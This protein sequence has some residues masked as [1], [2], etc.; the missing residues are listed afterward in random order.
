MLRA[1]PRASRRRKPTASAVGRSERAEANSPARGAR[2][3]TRVTEAAPAHA[4]TPL[5]PAPSLRLLRPRRDRRHPQPHQSGRSY[6]RDGS[7]PASGRRFPRDRACPPRPPAQPPA[8]HPDGIPGQTGSRPPWRGARLD[9]LL[10]ARPA[11]LPL[12]R[13]RP[14]QGCGR[15][16]REATSSAG[17]AAAES[18][19]TRSGSPSPAH[20]EA[21]RAGV[22]G[23]PGPVRDH[24]GP[25][26]GPLPNR[27]L[28]S[29]PGTSGRAVVAGRSS[30]SS[31]LSGRLTRRSSQGT[32]FSAR[33]APA[34]SDGAPTHAAPT[35]GVQ[36]HATPTQGAPTQG[37]STQGQ[38]ARVAPTQDAPTQ[39]AQATR[40][41]HA[42]RSYTAARPHT[43]RR[44]RRKRR[45]NRGAVFAHDRQTDTAAA[46][47]PAATIASDGQTDP[48][49]GPRAGRWA[50]HQRGGPLA[51]QAGQ[52]PGPRRDWRHLWPRQARPV[53]AGRPRQRRRSLRRQ[54][55]PRTPACAW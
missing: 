4:P 36:A 42:G 19:G 33:T 25:A 2:A 39:G 9:R 24:G 35:Q 6:E 8:A 55:G 38:Q 41:A 13:S 32:R 14:R 30:L 44:G 31:D 20:R 17:T 16:L 34:G 15:P 18:A 26:A 45:A 22:P 43:G 49:S 7:G 53:P 46:R 21:A 3:S 40:R 23:S 27:S 47:V 50:R 28:R 10:S 37:A 51:V 5:R 52:W 48:A 12:G 11:L 1:T 54:A 29:D